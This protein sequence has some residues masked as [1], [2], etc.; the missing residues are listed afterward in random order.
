M[1]LYLTL[2]YLTLPYL[3]VSDNT[4]AEALLRELDSNGTVRSALVA[5]HQVLSAAGV[6]LQGVQHVDGSGLSRHNLI[7]PA[8]FVSLLRKMTRSPLRSVLPVGG[9]SGTLKHR[10]IGT[11]AEGRVFAKTG[12]E[13]GISGLSGYLMH[14]DDAV[15]EVTFSLLGNNGLGYGGL[16]RPFQ[17]AIVTAVANARV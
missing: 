10:F 8:T 15:G 5:C 11:A 9:R 2:P 13:D 3:Q 6:E 12:T 7:P 17:D 4:Y 1:F 14:Q 16:L